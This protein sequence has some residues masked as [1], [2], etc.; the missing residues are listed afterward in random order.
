M[1]AAPPPTGWELGGDLDLS[2]ADVED[3]GP[4][5][6]EDEADEEEGEGSTHR[7]RG[8]RKGKAKAKGKA[9]ASA[10]KRGKTGSVENG[11]KSCAPCNKMHPIIEFVNGKSMCHVAWNAC[12]NIRACAVAQGQEAWWEEVSNNPKKLHAVVSAY[13]VRIS[14]EIAGPLKRAK[15]HAFCIATYTVCSGAR[16]HR[17][18]L[19]NNIAR[20]WGGAER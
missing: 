15:K 11:M 4:G 3:E 20:V 7:G 19:G 17:G 9:L 1:A 13:L 14:P 6:A 18:L 12:R 2:D 10:K 16:R 8:R 5:G